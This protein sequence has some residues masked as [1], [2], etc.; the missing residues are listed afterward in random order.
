MI[1]MLFE[2]VVAGLSIDNSKNIFFRHSVFIMC[3][4]S[5]QL[6]GESFFYWP[7]T[8]CFMFLSC[9]LASDGFSEAAV[10]VG[11]GNVMI[12]VDLFVFQLVRLGGHRI[13]FP[14]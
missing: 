8:R 11:W 4:V 6:T 5:F 9:F 12:L 10:V 2:C 7:V 13:L 14:T 1:N 3:G